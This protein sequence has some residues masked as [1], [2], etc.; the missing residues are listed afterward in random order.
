MSNT[1]TLLPSG[2]T[3]TGTKIKLITFQMTFYGPIILLVVGII[4][5][6]CNFLTFTSRQLRRNSCAFYFLCSAIF[7]LLAITFGLISRLTADHFSSNL[8]NTNRIY[9]KFRAYFITAIP[10][11][12]TYLVL[13]SSIDRCMSS[14]VYARFRLFIQMKVA[15]RCVASAI[16]ISLVSCSHILIS[17]DLRPKCATLPGAYAMFDSMFVVFWFGII[18]H[19]LMLIFGFVTLVNIRRA[20]QQKIT[21]LQTNVEH[22]NQKQRRPEQKTD[23]Q[24]ILVRILPW[25]S[26]IFDSMPVYLIKHTTQSSPGRVQNCL[27]HTECE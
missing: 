25:D 23:K 22:I 13:L 12:A 26:R 27:R 7:E 3:I 16:G 14:S 4:G 2:V 5:C 19:M 15:Y 10:L 20:R 8:Q 11:I 17:Y 6:L 9:C 21:K 24:L 1:T 18:P